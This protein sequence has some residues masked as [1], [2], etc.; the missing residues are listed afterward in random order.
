MIRFLRVLLVLAS[1][2]MLAGAFMLSVYIIR[3]QPLAALA[4]WLSSAVLAILIASAPVHK[5][6]SVSALGRIRQVLLWI[7]VALS[8]LCVTQFVYI[9]DR[10][11]ND[12]VEGYVTNPIQDTDESGH[13]A[14]SVS[15]WAPSWISRSCIWLLEGAIFVAGPAVPFFVWSVLTRAVDRRKLLAGARDR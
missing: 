4:A 5:R 12:F 2:P 15:F 10:V 7:A 9:R 8:V 11:G 3:A 1:V 6:L 14:F 13:T